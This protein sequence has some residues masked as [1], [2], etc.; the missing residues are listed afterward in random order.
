MQYS[1]VALALA[2]FGH[3]VVASPAVSKATPVAFDASALAA[4][5]PVSELR[6]ADSHPH[7]NTTAPQSDF[8]AIVK[9]QEFPA[10]LLLCALDGCLSCSSFNLG[11]FPEEECFSTS[12]EF[13]SVAISQPSN[14]GLPFVVGV[15]PSPCSSLL[16]IPAVNECFNINGAIFDAFALLP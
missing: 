3:A 8:H 12:F 6:V 16:D 15:G 10:T 14:Q 2:L 9:R 1:F 11:S 5:F 7:L 13:F 4:S